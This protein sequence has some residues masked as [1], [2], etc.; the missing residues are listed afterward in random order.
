[1]WFTV[2]E[3]FLRCMPGRHCSAWM[4]YDPERHGPQR[5]VGPGFHDKV[6]DVVVTVPE[7]H[8][9]TYGDVAAALGMRSVARKVGHALAALPAER[10]DVPWH[11]VVN[12]QGRISRPVES[13]SGRRQCERLEQEGIEVDGA[14]RI[15]EFTRIRH[16][17]V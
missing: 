5:I 16:T 7:G 1:M 9:T 4:P 14:G 15:R 10:D 6:F 17:L 11:R 12:A 13:V 8:V 3:N 2:L